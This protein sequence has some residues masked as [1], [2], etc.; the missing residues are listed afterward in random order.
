[1]QRAQ[2]TGTGPLPA[3]EPWRWSAAETAAMV[4]GGRIT[5]TE[6]VLAHLARLDATAA[7][8][9]VTR[10]DDERALRRAAAVDAAVRD[11]AAPGP[12]TGVPVTIKDSVDVA[13]QSSPNGVG[14]LDGRIAAVDAPLVQHL[15]A[16]GA[17]VIGR[18]NAPEFSW[19]WHTDNPLFGATVNPWSPAHT[20]GGSSG[21]AAAALAA[22]VGAIAQ[23]S[24]AGGSLRWPAS[25]CG[26]STIRPTQHRVP[27][28]NT[29]SDGERSPAIDLMAVAGPLARTVGDLAL[30]LDVLA[31]P[32]WRDPAHVP[33]GFPPA[34]PAGHRRFGVPRLPLEVAPAVQA[35]L[36]EAAQ[37]LAAAGWRPV[38]VALPSVEEAAALWAALLNSDFHVTV[39]DTFLELGSPAL[40]LM[41]HVLDEVAEPLDLRGYVATLA[42]R[43]ALL[44]AWQRLLHDEVD[45]VLLPVCR[46]PTWAAGDDA[47]S[48]QRLRELYRANDPL[49]AINLLGLPAAV[50]PVGVFDGLPIGVQLVAARFA[51][52]T[53]LA[54][55]ADLE[56]SGPAP[57]A[58]L[59]ARP[60]G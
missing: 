34:P 12:L 13:G 57:L 8:N 28:H 42:R 58:A 53:A 24:D 23:G 17:I 27:M 29:T 20:P 40:R 44:R 3:G 9:A 30:V 36:D 16:A 55:A 52:R 22:G 19:R 31:R 6:V 18:T 26:V 54:A 10:R 11:G 37:R 50:Q 38:E 32:S 7:L 33:V 51:E 48:P 45:V 59:W 47:G 35:A 60:T 46:E 39:R 2:G 49:V 1:M 4:G 15:H 14:A 41:L 21:G 25:C 56:A 5:A 43:A